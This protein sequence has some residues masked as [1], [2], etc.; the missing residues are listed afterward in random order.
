MFWCCFKLRWRCFLLQHSGGVFNGDGV[1]SVAV[2]LFFC[3]GCVVL[4][5]ICAVF[6]GGDV[7]FCCGVYCVV[8]VALVLFLV[9]VVLFLVALV[10]FSVLEM[11]FHRQ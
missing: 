4:L 7:V 3:G 10:L 5:A 8:S 9:A 2:V 11:L 6:S 1:V